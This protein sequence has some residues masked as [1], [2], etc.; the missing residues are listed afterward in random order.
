MKLLSINQTDGKLIESFDEISDEE[1]DAALTRAQQT[2]RAY[3]R[4]S[5]V[6]RA[7]WLQEAAQ[8][9]DGESGKLGATDDPGNGQDVQGGNRG[10]AEVRARLPLLRGARRPASSPTKRSR[11]TPIEATS[12]T[13]RWGPSWPSCRGTFRSGRS[14]ASPLRP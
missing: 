1:L 12:A 9:L 10:S 14:C 3:R 6:E 4:T 2:F 5:L 11:P 13:C 7:R 8:I